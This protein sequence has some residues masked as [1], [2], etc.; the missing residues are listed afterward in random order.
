MPSAS[1]LLHVAAEHFRAGRLAEAERACRRV[2]AAEPDQAQAWLQLGLVC[3][4]LGRT[5]EAAGCYQQAIR[6]QPALAEAHYNLGNSLRNLG[7]VEEAVHSFQRALAIS[8]GFAAAAMNLGNIWAKHDR[9]DEALA[10]YQRALQ[11]QPDYAKAHN[12]LGNVLKDRGQPEAALAEFARATQLQPDFAAAHSNFL[13][14]LLFCPG[15]DA[16]QIAAEHRRWNREVAAG[17]APAGRPL[18]D[19]LR[20]DRPL[21]I[22]YVSPDFGDHV[23]GRNLLPLFKHHDHQQ[24]QI[25]AYSVSPR[26]DPLTELFQGY[27]DLWHDAAGLADETLARQIRF[28]RI[29]ILV[30][31]TLHMAGNRLLLFARRPAPLQVTCAGYPGTTGLAT[32]DYRLTDRCLD[33]ADATAARGAY[34]EAAGPVYSEQSLRLPQAF[35]CYDPLDDQPPVGPLPTEREGRVTFGS[36]NNFAKVNPQVLKLWARVLHAVPGSRL[37]LLAAEGSHR[38][39]AIELLER[40]GV[41]GQRV[42]FVDKGPRQQYLE[43]YHELDIALDTLPYN[44]HTTSLDAL[45][46]GVPLVTLVGQTV[47]GRAGLSQLTS[48]GLAELIADTPDRFVQIAADLAGDV[49][50]LAELRGTLRQRL[51]ASPLMD[52]PAFARSVEAAYREMWQRLVSARG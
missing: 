40:E 4:A 47:V 26:R 36:L 9:L 13:Y 19:D 48:L 6:A 10:C 18:P 30:D 15:I 41:S 50:R 11:I 28:D 32:I 20:P 52:G 27:V 17:L 34:S 7:R 29:D 21:R 39:S 43:Y 37:V 49:P 45:W 2:L 51:Q 35:W 1:E 5:D 24:F 42:R 25:V 44:G 46:M 38:Q 22:G 23:V 31:T 8:P 12:N 33:P 16:Q 3:D 14:T